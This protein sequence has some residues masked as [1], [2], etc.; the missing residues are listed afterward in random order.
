MF[1]HGINFEYLVQQY[2]YFNPDSQMNHKNKTQLADR[3]HLIEQF[4]FEPIHLL[5]SSPS[6]SVTTCLRECF[7]FGNVVLAFSKLKLPFW[8]I[9][10]HEIAIGGLDVKK[11][12]YIFV[13]KSSL[14]E[15]LIQFF[16]DKLIIVYSPI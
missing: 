2:P 3:K 1:F 6:Y 5:E 7:Q 4:G 11:C 14:K 12:R 16:P 10:F 15:K 8:Q 13:Q 9:S